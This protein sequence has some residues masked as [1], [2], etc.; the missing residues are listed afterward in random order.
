MRSRIGKGLL[1]LLLTLGLL[2]PSTL[3]SAQS[4]TGIVATE[5]PV[6]GPTLNETDKGTYDAYDGTGGQEGTIEGPVSRQIEEFIIENYDAALQL[7]DDDPDLPVT[8]PGLASDAAGLAESLL[9]APYLYGGKGWD[10]NS[11]SFASVTQIKSTSYYY[12]DPYTENFQWGTGID[13]AGLVFWAFNKADGATSYSDPSNPIPGGAPYWAEGSMGLWNS[14]YLQQLGTSIPTVDDLHTGYV[15]FLAEP[16]RHAAM[17]V[18]DGY[19]VHSRGGVGVEKKTLSAWLNLPIGSET[20][21]DYFLGYGRIVAAGLPAP[22]LI[23]PPNWEDNVDTLPTFQ[24]EPVTGAAG[25]ALLVAADYLPDDAFYVMPIYTTSYTL[26][27]SDIPGF[28]ELEGDQLHAWGV[29][30]FD[31]SGELGELS[32]VWYFT[33]KVSNTPPELSSGYV[34]PTG[35]TTSTNF[36]YYVSYYDADGDSPS[37]KYVYIDG[38]A[39]TMSLYS[40]SASNGVYRYGPKTLAAGSHNYY[41]YFTDGEGGTARLPASGTYS[42]PSVTPLEGVNISIQPSTETVG[43]GEIFEL[44]IQADAGDQPV[45]GIDAFV[46][47]VPAYLEVLSVTPGASLPTV[48]EN[49]YDNTAGTIDYGAGKLGAPFPTDT[50]TVATIEFRA[51]ASTSPSTALTFSID[52]PRET[53]VDYA[54]DD[55]TGTLTGGTVSITV[56]APVFLDPASSENICIGQTFTLEIKTN[57]DNEQTVSGVQAFIDFDPTYLEVISVTPGASLTTVLENNYDNTAGTID[58]SAGKLGAPFP[59]GE[60]TVA[61]IEFKALAE[62]NGTTAVTFSFSGPRTTTVDIGGNPIPGIH[63]DATVEI[64]PGA[65]VDISVVLQGGSRPEVGWEVPITIKFFNPGADVITDTPL[66]QFDLTTTKSDGTAVCQCTVAPG[67]YDVTILSEHTLINVKRNVVISTPSTAV[68]MGILLEGNANDDG[69]INISDFGI[70]A[71]AYMCTEGEPCYDARADFDCNGIVNI[72]DF[73]LLAVNYM[74]MSPI[75]IS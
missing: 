7:L 4:P 49:T 66:E 40:G 9:G 50:F 75:D 63:G 73:G 67:T 37:T 54:G 24:W 23:S 68:D 34:G 13:C 31:S 32:E 14:P 33:T 17:Y 56:D 71:V 61:T 25:Y 41:F 20:Y 15:L 35:G 3:L 48:L 36:Y 65:M 70:L 58:Y 26:K 46:D 21:S 11:G 62:T 30:A 1:T 74:E 52:P 28:D 12:Y 16:N 45:S 55:V 59:T 69:I 42:G 2:L 18:G 53:R 29:V 27:P 47:F 5:T 51:L 57:V 72:S 60:F 44:I 43:V 10:Y 64:I 38:T 22:T 8:N 39:Y 6:A 19:V